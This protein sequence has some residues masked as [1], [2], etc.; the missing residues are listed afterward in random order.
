MSRGGG[1][2][3]RRGGHRY[4]RGG[5]QR[6]REAKDEQRQLIDDSSEIIKT[7]KQF[8]LQLDAKHDRHERIV[9]LSRDVTIESKRIIF[10][11]HTINS[12]NDSKKEQILDQANTRLKQVETNLFQAIAKELVGEDPHQ[13]LRA[14]SAGLQEYIEAK[15]FYQFMVSASIP[16]WNEIQ[17]DLTFA[18]EATEEGAEASEIQ[19]PVLPTEYMLGV[20]DLTGEL[21]RRC[22]NCVGMGELDA[23]KQLCGFLRQV[24]RI[25]AGFDTFGYKE[26]GRKTYVMRQSL[27]KT[28]NV[29]YTIQVRGSEVPKHLLAQAIHMSMDNPDEDEGFY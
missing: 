21:M 9:K 1:R 10:L 26:F 20:G 4:D 29:C 12:S 14:F 25:F 7:F 6:L 17:K 11:I 24:Y 28:E 27:A 22:I 2:G 16:H 8:A 13:F 5:D 19:T 3:N 15:T 18:Q 23:C